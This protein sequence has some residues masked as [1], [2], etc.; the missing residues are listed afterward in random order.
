[1]FLCSENNIRPVQCI[2]TAS[3][4]SFLIGVTSGKGSHPTLFVCLRTLVK[5]GQYS[6]SMYLLC[7]LKFVCP[8]FAINRKISYEL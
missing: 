1:M 4:T 6:D 5:S 3:F 8:I 7:N 2:N